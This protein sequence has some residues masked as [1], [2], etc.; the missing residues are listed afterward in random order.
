LKELIAL[1]GIVYIQIT[2]ENTSKEM[3]KECNWKK[4]VIAIQNFPS[5]FT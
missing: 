2:Q 3:E 4:E 1:V 5:L